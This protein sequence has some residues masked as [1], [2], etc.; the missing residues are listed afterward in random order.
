MIL[1]LL[2]LFSTCC[3]AQQT[4]ETVGD[5]GFFFLF[6]ILKSSKVTF[7]FNN[8]VGWSLYKQCDSRWGSTKM[9]NCGSTLCQKGCLEVKIYY[10]VLI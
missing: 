8:Y 4:N 5:A 9:G 3:I 6:S 1:F 2:L 7:H 10:F